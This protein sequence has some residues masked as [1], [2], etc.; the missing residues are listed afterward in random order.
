VVQL[1]LPHAELVG[2]LVAG[3][4]GNLRDRLGGQL[5]VGMEVH[6]AWH[7]LLL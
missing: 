3:V 4:L 6:E 7:E 2:R 1:D 5:E